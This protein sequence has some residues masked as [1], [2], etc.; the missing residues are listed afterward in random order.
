[1]TEEEA[2]QLKQA[3]AD[4]KEQV[5]QKDQRIEELEG[6]LIGAML[7]IEE[8]E[9]RQAKDS[10]NSS[11]PPSS[12]GLGRKVGKQRQKS[13]QP[14]GGQPGHQGHTLMQVQVPDCVIVHR[15]KQCE[16]CQSD[17]RQELGTVKERRQVHDLPD[18][19]LQVQEHRVEEICCPACQHLTRGT[20]PISIEAPAQYGPR[21]QAVAVYLSQFQLLPLGRICEA[22]EDLCHAQVSQASVVSW[23]TKAAKQLGPTIEHLK[24]LLVEGSLQHADETGIRIKGILH[25]VHVNATHWLTLYSWHRKRGKEA[26]EAIGI[27][28][29]FRGRAMHD[30]WVSYDQY[31]CAHSLCGAHLL[32]DCV[33]V[34][35]QEKQ[36]W[37]QEMFDHLLIM[38]KVAEQWRAQ[39]ATSIP[40][41]VR[42]PLLAQYFAIVT[43]GF[44]AHAAQAPPQSNTGPKKTGR[45]KQEA[46]KNLLDAFLKRADQ[47]LGFLDDLSVPFTNDVTAYCTPSAWLACWLKLTVIFVMRVLTGWW[48]QHDPTAIGM[49]YGNASSSPP[50]P[51]GLWRHSI[52]VSGFSRR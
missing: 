33:Y 42:D 24:E 46:S 40:K 51:H 38:A 17:L 26:L 47:V 52:D 21:V 4:L 11:K 49:I 13:E 27:W 7:R 44:A 50:I 9:R 2:K 31:V 36:P 23:I 5:V 37:A 39:G 15:P 14:S 41:E 3:Y 45:K 1:M 12:D 8:L 29:R 19:R 30:R 10:H 32:R 25:W 18:L 35:E 16:A 22:L 6:L 20:F 34:A 28:P 48:E 43:S